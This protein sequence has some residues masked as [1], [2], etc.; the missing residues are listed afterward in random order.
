MADCGVF[1]VLPVAPA[2]Q[3]YDGN[4]QELLPSHAGELLQQQQQ[5]QQQQHGSE[6]KGGGVKPVGG[7]MKGRRS[8]EDACEASEGVAAASESGQ[9]RE[10]FGT[11]Q[12]CKRVRIGGAAGSTEEGQEGEG[13]EQMRESRLWRERHGET[14]MP[15]GEVVAGAKL[16]SRSN[17]VFPKSRS[18]G[19]AFSKSP[20][21]GGVFPKSPSNNGKFPKSPFKG[22]AFPKSP[23]CGGVFEGLR[24][25]VV[26][27]NAVNRMVVVQLL[28]NL[29]VSC[30]VAVN[31]HKAVEACRSTNYHI[32]FM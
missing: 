20:S 8:A 32:I 12:G 22:G 26:E 19:G 23:S 14:R 30:D 31:G 7:S 4:K 21:T 25:L 3:D 18:N 10:V 6:E 1:P 24:C 13:G 29:R 15:L 5:Q 9:G 17:G 2:L 16:K 11:D 27:D 28:R